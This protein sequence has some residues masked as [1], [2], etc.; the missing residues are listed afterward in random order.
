MLSKSNTD[1]RSSSAT[2]GA[3]WSLNMGGY[4]LSMSVN[5]GQNDLVLIDTKVND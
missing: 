2:G 5:Y 4:A 1:I 3:D